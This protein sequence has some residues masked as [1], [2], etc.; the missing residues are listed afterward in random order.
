M[1]SQSVSLRSP[2]GHFVQSVLCDINP[3]TLSRSLS[4]LEI[5]SGILNPSSTM[6]SKQSLDVLHD[7]ESDCAANANLPTGIVGLGEV[8]KRFTR[9]HGLTRGV[10]RVSSGEVLHLD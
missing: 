5:C 1:Q 3:T 4:R 9:E 10:A 6:E 2:D 8:V 7:Q